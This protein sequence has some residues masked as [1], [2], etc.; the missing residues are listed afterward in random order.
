M[1]YNFY[2]LVLAENILKNQIIDLTHG[3][4]CLANVDGYA[5]GMYFALCFVTACSPIM[6]AVAT[7][8]TISCSLMILC[9][10]CIS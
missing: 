10:V 8:I 3:C 1:S 2:M 9:S 4:L 6:F 7:G 5:K